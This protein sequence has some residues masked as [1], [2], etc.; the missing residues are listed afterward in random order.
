LLAS[1]V[2]AATGSKG[3][4]SMTVVNGSSEMDTTSETVSIGFDAG[5]V[6]AD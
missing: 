5:V 6:A 2:G 1:L 3:E 4:P